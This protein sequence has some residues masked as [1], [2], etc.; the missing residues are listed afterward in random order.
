[1]DIITTNVS[2]S[3]AKQRLSELINHVAYGRRRIVIASR[4]RPKAALITI[5]DLNQ[6]KEKTARGSDLHERKA[7]LKRA[8]TLYKKLHQKKKILPDPV[9][10][11]R[12]LRDHHDDEY[13]DRL[14]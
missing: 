10:M 1:M 13:F 11:L 12:N 2:V 9:K 8:D 14:R 7:A 5:D 6:L 3:D 4:G